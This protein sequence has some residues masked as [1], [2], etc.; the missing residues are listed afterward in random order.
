MDYFTKNKMLFWCV[1]V[2]VVLNAVTLT[3]VWIK[4]P[5]LGPPTGP[6]GRPDGHKI[7]EERLGLSLE[8]GEEFE[9]IRDEHFMRTRRLQDDTHKVRLDLLDEMFALEPDETRIE[10]LFG[11]LG[12]NQN[13]FERNLYQHF[14][15]LK[16]ACDQQQ[17]EELKFMLRDLIE[18]TRPG[19]PRGHPPGPGREFGP[20]H[21]PP[22]RR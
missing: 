16:N 11:E 5:P 13:Q 20:G 9:R 2:L 15:E 3:S 7:M 6:D 17:A 21:R 14:Q 12:D 19:G 22:P 1:I 8:Q 18:S 10:E 4:R